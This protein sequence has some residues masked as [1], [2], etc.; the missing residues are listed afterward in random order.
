MVI[1]STPTVLVGCFSQLLLYKTWGGSSFLRFKSLA[2]QGLT[3][4]A[5][6]SVNK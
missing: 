2:G 3:A 4:V 5:H 6:L 1:G